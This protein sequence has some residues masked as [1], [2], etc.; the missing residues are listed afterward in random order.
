MP[1]SDAQDKT[2]DWVLKATTAL[3][4]PALVWSFKLS[5]EVA[6]LNLKIESQ[7]KRIERVEIDLKERIK[8]ANEKLDKILDRLSK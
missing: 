7:E 8:K 5:T 2:L 4:I 6:V 3:V 1:S